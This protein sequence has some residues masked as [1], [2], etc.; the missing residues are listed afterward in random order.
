MKSIL[1]LFS[2][3]KK[4]ATDDSTSSR[5]VT[6]LSRVEPFVDLNIARA[7]LNAFDQSVVARFEG[8]IAARLSS[9][10]LAQLTAALSGVLAEIR[11]DIHYLTA[12]YVED[13]RYSDPNFNFKTPDHGND[14]PR[15]SAFEIDLRGQITGGNW[16]YAESDGRW[17]GPESQSSLLF[18]SLDQGAYRVEVDVV[19]EI[20]NGVIDGMAMLVNGSSVSFRRN[21]P[22]L[23]VKLEADFTVGGDYKLPFWSVKFQFSKLRSPASLS[24]SDDRRTLAIRVASLRFIKVGA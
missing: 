20:E 15:V 5:D 6:L 10:S 17:A 1:P 14:K 8:E 9:E 13:R 18:P 23:P 21:G 7:R 12:A 3:E 11:A 19:D 22:A 24:G 16:Y 4:Q 2:G